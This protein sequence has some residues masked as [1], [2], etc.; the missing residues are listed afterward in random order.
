MY[1]VILLNPIIPD[2]Q[3]KS[4]PSLSVATNTWL[5]YFASTLFHMGVKCT[6]YGFVPERPWPLGRLTLPFRSYKYPF[7]ESNAVG[8][9][10]LLFLRSLIRFTI[11]FANLCFTALKCKISNSKLII[12]CFTCLDHS[13]HTSPELLSAK[14]VSLLLNIKFTAIVGDGFPPLLADNYLYL[15]YSA[16][17]LIPRSKPSLHFDGGI[18][19][20]KSLNFSNQY[21]YHSYSSKVLLYCGSLGV[22]GG[23]IQLLRNLIVSNSN[24]DFSLHIYGQGD[25][26]ELSQYQSENIDIQCFGLVDDSTLHEACSSCYAFVNPRPL[27]FKPNLLNFPSK[28]LHYLGYAKP[29]LS[30]RSPGISHDYDQVL[31]YYN[32]NTLADEIK[33]LF[34]LSF[35]EYQLLCRSILDFSVN[36]TWSK[37]SKNLNEFLLS[38]S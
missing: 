1:N 34:R 12:I 23:I 22:H 28:L 7:F 8:Y 14:L 3:L 20:P 37:R 35:D 33:S 30:T 19:I 21:F 11:L 16:G 32:N 24:F 17:R 6:S 5:A 13:L 36:N 29:I 4:Y 15:S 31:S 10:N 25:S 26:N 18:N 27:D 2:D 9:L 38:S